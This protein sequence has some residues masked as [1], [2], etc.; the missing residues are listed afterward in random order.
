[1]KKWFSLMLVCAMTLVLLPIGVFAADPDGTP[2]GT[3]EELAGMAADGTY[4]LNADITLTGEWLYPEFSGTLDGNGY[5]I[6]LNGVTLNGGLFAVLSGATVKNLTVVQSAENTFRLP[7]APTV[8]S[9]GVIAA[10]ATG[11]TTLEN[12]V[13]QVNIVQILTGSQDI[14]GLIGN[15][16]GGNFVIS[17]CVYAGII[18]LERYGYGRHV[19]GI[20]GSTWTDTESLTITNCATYGT[21]IG[22]LTSAGIFANS[23]GRNNSAT[24][25][26][27]TL[28]ENI[29]YADVTCKTSENA[30]GIIAY[31]LAPDGGTTV[32]CNNINYG[33]ITAEASN[34]KA[35]GIGGNLRQDGTP[36]NNEISGNINYGTITAVQAAPIYNNVYGSDIKPDAENNYTVEMV[37]S[38]NGP[39]PPTT[40]VL[41]DGSLDELN[42]AY[43]GTYA[44]LDGR[45]TLKWAME[46]GLGSTLPGKVNPTF[47]GYQ[48]SGEP[49]DGKRSIRFIATIS[50]LSPDATGIQLVVRTA[51][52]QS[53]LWKAETEVVYT[54]VNANGE[55]VMAEQYGAEYLYTAI[56]RN[57]P[58]STGIIIFEIRTFTVTDGVTTYSEATSVSIDIGAAE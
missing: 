21:Y 34:G 29:N 49:S 25:T 47:V 39:I 48:L 41:D 27:L 24:L 23:Q 28:T 1:M 46:A 14:G 44:M 57:I 2:I 45:I 54:S 26:D 5:T 50:D 7:E 4:Y 11:N 53:Q 19:S 6:T 55:K 36:A 42:Q 31:R 3:A 9:F 58:V 32:I 37:D 10:R 8:D 30:S 18:G 40:A 17:N 35:G 12:V 15:V 22:N 43:P 13:V 56:L 38:G 16:H 52:G 33:N 51:D 20:I